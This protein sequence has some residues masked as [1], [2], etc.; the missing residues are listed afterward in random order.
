MRALLLHPEDSPRRGPWAAERWD[1]LIDLGK[2]SAYS[3][4]S[5]AAQY[6]CPVFRN[7]SFR[8]GIEDVKQ[9]RLT[10]SA[11]RGR[12]VGRA[13]IDWWEL[14]SLTI[15]QP[16]LTVLSLSRMVREIKTPVELWATRPGWP[17]TAVAALTGQPLRS[18]HDD[19]LVRLAAQAMRSVGILRRFSAA[20]I[21]GIALDKYDAGY[22]WRSRLALRPRPHAEPVVLVPSAYGNVSRGAAEY[23]RLLPRQQFLMVATRRSAKHA[24][25]PPNMDTRD[26]GAYAEANPSSDELRS[27]LAEW[28]Q[29][30]THLLTSGEMGILAQTGML[31]SFP[32]WLRNGLR[33]REAWSAVL[34]REP[35]CAVLCGDDS[36]PYTRMPVLLATTRKIPTLDFHHGA[37]D[38]RYLLKDLPCDL[39]LA[40]SEMERDYLV[41]VCGLPAERLAM[42]APQGT[43]AQGPAGLGEKSCAVFFSEPYESAGMRAEEVYREILPELCR[44]ARENRRTVIIK[45]HPFE[46][47]AQRQRMVSE[48]LP[49]DLHRI[50]AL[51]DGPLTK[52]LLSKAW[53]GLTLES[54][55]AMDCRK[56]GV[57]CFLCSW[58]VLSPFGYAE[59]YARY[60]IGELLSGADE[61]SRIPDRLQSLGNCTRTTPLSEPLDP[62]L[63]EAWLKDAHQPLGMRSV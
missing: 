1:L 47:R 63:F 31:D 57:C 51:V 44:L 62:V 58:L 24:S 21:S 22:W 7:S 13:G 56:A 2:S 17:A 39:Y 36:N 9:T 42:G 45:L 26:L 61:L 4:A 32:D 48:I 37:L 23:G 16:A 14:W 20:E 30:R 35:V 59:Q 19:R 29:L 54:T 46:S 11:G 8:Q 43:L 18:F 38:G 27:M 15:A 6:R 41:R 60:G 5:W 10:L 33:V 12:M 52:E 55:A 53:F 25:L 40:K 34:D 28:R 50:T 49:P 3:E